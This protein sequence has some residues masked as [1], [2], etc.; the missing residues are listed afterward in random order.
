MLDCKLTIILN[1]EDNIPL[2]EDIYKNQGFYAQA[3][4]FHHAN[5]ISYFDEYG[6]HKIESD[7]NTI[8]VPLAYMSGHKLLGQQYHIHFLFDVDDYVYDHH[9]V[10][11]YKRCFMH[12]VYDAH[13][14][15]FLS[16][17]SMKDL[18]KEKI[19]YQL[20]LPNMMH[21]DLPIKYFLE[22]ETY[23][24]F[25]SYNDFQCLLI[26]KEHKLDSNGNRLI[27]KKN[28]WSKLWSKYMLSNA[29]YHR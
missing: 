20:I 11:K 1:L 3:G 7:L 24:E 25:G 10:D 18:L 23:S 27:F 16:I 2:C 6:E 29:R 17:Q 9:M 13:K 28:E 5:C 26:P 21:I 19:D 22:G 8:H 12:G 14:K 15:E 4:E